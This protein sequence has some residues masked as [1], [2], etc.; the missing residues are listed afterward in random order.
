MGLQFVKILSTEPVVKAVD[1][2]LR[3]HLNKGDKVLWFLSGGSA[4]K[5][6]AAVAAQLDVANLG[7][8]TV[9][10]V[11]ER[12]G[13]PGHDD[14]NWKQLNNAGFDLP[15]A[16]KI[17][18]LSSKS[19]PETASDY[20][21][22]IERAINDADYVIA[23]AGIGPDGH[24]LGIKPHSPSVDSPDL[25]VSYKWE[26]FGRITATAEAIKRMDKIIVYAAGAEKKEQLINLQSDRPASEQPAQL[27]KQC[28]EVIIYN[29]QIG[30][31]APS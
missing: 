30:K 25:V 15:A 23:L 2:D 22:V 5:I 3:E 14:S 28:P 11:D 17:E 8:L 20:A 13:R 4:I 26:D 27:L 21:K 19:M 7:N 16:G 31:P 29:D 6:E 9:A 24:T 12:Y 1:K 10:L 18:V